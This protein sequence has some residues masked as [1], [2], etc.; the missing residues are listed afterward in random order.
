MK[1]LVSGHVGWGISW[2]I[3]GL[4]IPE[5]NVVRGK[6]YRFVV[7]GGENPETP[8][9]YHPFYITDDPVGGYQ[10]KT[11]EEKEVRFPSFVTDQ[12]VETSKSDDF[13]APRYCSTN[14]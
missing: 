2:Y 4:L 5:I 6:K 3:N 14:S 8:A 1:S 10:H 7:E 11:P 13:F 12:R 9:R